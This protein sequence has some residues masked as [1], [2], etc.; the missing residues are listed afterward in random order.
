[1][2]PRAGR[3]VAHADL[4]TSPDYVRYVAAT[5]ELW[6]TEPAASQI[7]I[8]ALSMGS[9][10][11]LSRSAAIPV[12]NGPESLVIDERQGRA[13]THRW[14]RSTV[15]IDVK[16]RAV[17]GDWPNGCAAS[18][19]NAVDPEHGLL[20]AACSEG[21]VTVLDSAHD[22][23]RL[24]T[25]AEGAGFDVVGYS[26]MLRHLYLAGSAC[27]CLVVLAVSETGAL[28]HL[29]RFAASSSTHC[30]VADDRGNAWACDPDGGRLWRV[31]DGWP[32][33]G[34]GP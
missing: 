34:S 7:E 20:F 4:A 33:S 28:S 27:H 12:D 31:P 32:P 8:F 19:G 9:P 14:Q 11:S 3:I 2:D 22:G 17:V 25:I 6:V 23:R 18:R 24:S 10:P 16:S 5:N 15:A 30:A 26:S 21:T 13:F 29:G 1:M